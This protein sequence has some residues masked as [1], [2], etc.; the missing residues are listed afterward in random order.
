[1]VKNKQTMRPKC[2]EANSIVL[3]DTKGRTRIRLDAGGKDGCACI[4]LFA[5]DGKSVQISSQPDG[6]ILINIFGKRCT[7]HITLGLSPDGSGGL[8]ISNKNGALGT[9]L[10]EEPKTSTHRLLLFKQGKHFWNTPTGKKK[11]D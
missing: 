2:I 9:M 5:K 10:G 3:T 4:S 8:S 6:G 1:M 7:S 11:K